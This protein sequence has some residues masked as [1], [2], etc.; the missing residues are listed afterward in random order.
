MNNKAGSGLLILALISLILP[1]ANTASAQEIPEQYD[2][3]S[4]APVDNEWYWGLLDDPI[5]LNGTTSVAG[6]KSNASTIYAGGPGY[7]AVTWDS[8]ATWSDTLHFSTQALNADT[9]EEMLNEDED[10]TL[11]KEQRAEILRSYLQTELEEE[12][13]AESVESLLEEI[14][15]DELTDADSIDNIE[16][17]KDLDLQMDHDLTR[18]IAEAEFANG[19]KLSDFDSFIDRYIILTNNAADES[20]A[21]HYAAKTSAVSQ[22]IPT[23]N[24]VYAVTSG[25]IYMTQDSGK[26]WEKYMDAPDDASVLSFS[27]SRDS[28]T[29]IIGTTNSALLSR[30]GG[31]EWLSLN[32]VIEGAVYQVHINDSN[33]WLLSTHNLYHST[34]NGLTWQKTDA[35]LGES[36]VMIDVV[37]GQGNSLLALTNQS[38]YLTADGSAWNGIPTIPDEIIRQVISSDSTL[39]SF[40]IRTDS[41]VFEYTP[42]GWIPRNNLLFANELGEFTFL[43]DSYSLAA[44]ASPTGLWLAQHSQQLEI[45]DEYAALFK[46]WANEPNDYEIIQKALEA[47][48][49][50]D[51]VERKWGLRSGLAWLLPTFTFDYYLRQKN[52][53]QQKL[54]ATLVG[55][56]AYLWSETITYKREKQSYWQVMALWNINIGRILKDDMAGIRQE[57][58]LKNRRSAL[59]K[60]VIKLINKRRANQT[61]LALDIPK[62]P[63][64]KKAT[65]K[66]IIKATLSMQETEANLHYLTGGYYFSAIHRNDSESTHQ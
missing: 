48:Y 37:P 49:L 10:V 8:G 4:T 42:S 54:T 2:P 39:S 53:D 59:V 46:T 22:I 35:P 34:D 25:A 21:I 20:D 64:T 32:D 44:M 43:S 45:S 58:Q 38:L 52:T 60:N 24:A 7:V 40:T 61:T 29:R 31:T 33:I 55:H 26:S 30:D 41:H 66:K 17:L 62:L 57:I 14:T 9:E 5:L 27:L 51:A 13:D 19:A 18:V 11:T 6:D 36:E 56:E 28:Q 15:D 50:D 65:K 47:H 63:E 12:L 3:A 16:I 23:D 1:A